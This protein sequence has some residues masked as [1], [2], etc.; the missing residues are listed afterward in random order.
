MFSRLRSKYTPIGLDIGTTA[1]RAVQLSRR[2][3]RL[4]VHSVLEGKIAGIPTESAVS[5]VGESSHSSEDLSVDVEIASVIG[6]LIRRGGFVGSDVALHC[7]G[8]K[9]DLR[10][11]ELPNAHE[12]SRDTIIG[13]IRLQAVDHLPF[14]SADAVY[15]YIILG[16]GSDS[17]SVS[18]MSIVADGRWIARCMSLVASAGLHCVCIDAL[19]CVLWRLIKTS[20]PSSVDSSVEDIP[21]DSS[22]RQERLIAVLDMGHFYSTLVVLNNDGPLFCR[23]FPVGGHKLTDT[24]SSRLMVDFVQ[25]ERIKQAYGLDFVSELAASSGDL[26]DLCASGSSG[27][28][29]GS[30]SCSDT[31]VLSSDRLSV[32]SLS[33]NR[34]VGKIIYAALQNDLGDLVEGLTR[35]L[36]YVINYRR[37]ASLERLILCG[38]ASETNNMDR[39][40][41]NEFGIPV[42]RYSHLLLD[43]LLSFLPSTRAVAGSWGVSLGLLVG[44]EVFE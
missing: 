25:A 30:G 26:D 39:F 15:D 6:R 41:S 28:V 14:P 40:F 20:W 17:D 19:P 1:I 27:V 32:E 31:A 24:L 8:G 34:S 44:R 35:S 4:D 16:S 11:L 10:P 37:G 23:R 29:A 36:N 21:E 2:A 5:A 13:A 42:E 9:L 7:P 33:S 3:D 22:E 43:S 12:L 18:V 38:G